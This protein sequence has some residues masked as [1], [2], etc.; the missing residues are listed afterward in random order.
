M[1][2]SLILLLLLVTATCVV[3][4]VNIPVTRFIRQN[5]YNPYYQVPNALDILLDK[6]IYVIAMFPAG[7]VKY[8]PDTNNLAFP[9]AGRVN[10]IR[11]TVLTRDNSVAYPLYHI[12]PQSLTVPMSL[13]VAVLLK[14]NHFI[15]QDYRHIV[16]QFR[17]EQN[18]ANPKTIII[19]SYYSPCDQCT[20]DLINLKNR[21][22]VPGGAALILAYSVPFEQVNGNSI[23]LRMAGFHVYQIPLGNANNSNNSKKK[24]NSKG[25]GTH[26]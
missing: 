17:Q 13:W 24:P 21:A 14:T 8:Y 26:H 4:G 12:G 1:K 7:G 2:S 10:A 5:L 6:H 18:G 25:K 9:M 15:L 22:N 23:R 19:Y 3:S 16:T 11:F 20:R